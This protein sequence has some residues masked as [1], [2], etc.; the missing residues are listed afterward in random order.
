M[1]KKLVSGLAS[2][3]LSRN[4]P[5]PIPTSISTGFELPNSS[6]Q[7]IGGPCS[8]D[9]GQRSE[10]R[11]E[12][13]PVSFCPL[14]AVLCPLRRLAT[15][16]HWYGASSSGGSRRGLRTAQLLELAHGH[17]RHGRLERLLGA[18]VPGY[19]EPHQPAVDLQP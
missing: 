15:K 13:G 7:S 3:L 18:H 19:P 5:L 12:A 9:R 11:P 14:S 4:N 6:A 8:E 10:D 2:A 17:A 16:C 1:P